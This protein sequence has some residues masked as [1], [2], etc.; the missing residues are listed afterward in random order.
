LKFLTL[1]Q[2]PIEI[3]KFLKIWW[4][5]PFALGLILSPPLALIA[6]NKELESPSNSHLVEPNTFS[7]IG[8]INMSED[9]YQ[10]RVT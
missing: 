6:K 4:C 8:K 2:I 10:L 9:L 5:G 3:N 1:T 7:P